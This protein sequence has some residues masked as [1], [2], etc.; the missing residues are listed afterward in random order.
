MLTWARFAAFEADESTGRTIYGYVMDSCPDNNFW[1]QVDNFHLD[2]SEAYLDSLGLKDSWNGREISW[3]YLDGVPSGY[4]AFELV[5]CLPTQSR[6]V[7]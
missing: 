5:I 2:F 4:D 3:Q 7:L 1:C 6:A